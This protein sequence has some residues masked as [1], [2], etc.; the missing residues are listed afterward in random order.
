MF[1]ILIENFEHYH[2]VTEDK[3]SN[4]FLKVNLM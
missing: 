3:S 4:I 1:K 2:D